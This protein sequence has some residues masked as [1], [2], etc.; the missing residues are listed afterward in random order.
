MKYLTFLDYSTLQATGRCTEAKI[1]ELEKENQIISQKY[2]QDMKSVREQ[3]NQIMM[4]VQQNPR[5]ANIKPEIL[6]NKIH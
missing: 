5:L 1:K 6:V 3:M 4:M 2:D